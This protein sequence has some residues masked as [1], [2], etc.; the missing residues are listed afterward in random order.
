MNKTI[1]ISTL[2]TALLY[3]TPVCLVPIHVETKLDSQVIEDVCTEEI[4]SADLGE[5]LFRA[6][7]SVSLV[8]RSG[9]SNDI[10]VRGQKK[11]NINVTIDG[12]KIYGACPNRM[13]PPISH[14]A[15]NAVDTIEINE[16]PFDVEDF[17]VL[18]GDVKVHT[19]KPTKETSG[20]AGVNFGSFGYQKV[21]FNASGGTDTFRVIVGASAEK[22]EQYRDGDG[23]N[24]VQQQDLYIEKNLNGKP[25]N[26]NKLKGL[27]YLPNERDADAFAKKTVTTKLFWEIV[28]NHEINMGYTANRS[29]DILYPS[30]PMDANYDDSDIY[31]FGYSAKE[32]GVFSK[33]LTFDLYQTKVDHPMSN[34]YRKASEKNP[35]THALTTKVNGVKLKNSF[36]IANHM[37]KTGIDYSLRNWDGNYEMPNGKKTNSIWDVDTK[38]IGFFVNDTVQI[39]KWEFDTGA[40]VDATTI[41]T[42]DPKF[43]DIELDGVSG[44]SVVSYHADSTTRY[45]VGAGHSNR[46]P[47]AREL[48]LYD[49]NSSIR[50]GNPT[51][52]KITNTE[53][54]VGVQKHYTNATIKAKLFY[55][56]LNDFILYNA[57]TNHF[58]NADAWIWGLDV[59]GNY[60]FSDAFWFTLGL[61]KQKGEKK[62]PLAK[63]TDVDLPEIP[64]FKITMAFN[65]QVT[66]NLLFGAEMIAADKWEHFDIDN[67]EQALDAYG[68]LNLKATQSFDSGIE[69][70]VGIDN[71]FDSTYALSNTYEDLTLISGGGDVMLMNE[72]RRYLYTQLKYRF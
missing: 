72:S 44:N 3:A 37:L 52:K 1:T 4:K 43:D 40:R 41:S 58:E 24:F 12:A 2:A 51:L 49:K 28:K 70:S 9:I 56:M 48:Y 25:S 55:S 35:M 21:Y 18:S 63:Q 39:Q 34:R 66:A 68:V 10:I 71:L 16:G 22:A 69:W 11:D 7:P 61:A 31:T 36:E 67:G 6:S 45:F 32:L 8:R 14:I 38:N 13:D 53:I 60:N 42:K 65:Y 27:A 23:N 57:T 62:N 20:E 33:T 15:T 19:L 54:D 47:D 17:G 64:P 30:T 46:V 29:D 5:A 59:S 50:I 26:D